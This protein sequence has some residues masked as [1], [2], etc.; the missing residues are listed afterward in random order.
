MKKR[1]LA[2]GL[3]GVMTLSLFGCASS[4]TT[5][6]T[7]TAATEASAE[8]EKL[9]TSGH[10]AMIVGLPLYLGEDLGIY[11]DYGLDVERTHYISGPPQLEALPSGA[12][13]I[14]W[15]G[16]AAANTAVLQH[17]AKIIGVAGTD[18]SHK[19]FVREDSPIYASGAGHVDG[20]P[21]LYGTA[22]DWR[23]A[24]ILCEKG[25]IHYMNLVLALGLLGVSEDEV[26]I[27]HMDVTSALQAFKAGEG[28]VFV[29]YGT[30]TLEAE[31]L[32]YK[33]VETMDGIDS[34]TPAV[35]ICTQ[36]ILD[37]RP[38]VVI[39]YLKGSMDAMLY[40]Q[41]E[42]HLAEN[43]EA[44][45]I[46]MTEESGVEFTDE[47]VDSSWAMYA[48]PDLETAEE[49]CEIDA[50]GVSGFQHLYASPSALPGALWLPLK[51]WPPTKALVT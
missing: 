16:M 28:D 26:E 1:L 43:K 13:E 35:L 21:E 5:E 2:L 46:F 31:S 8:M 51:C 10:V 42:S 3:A 50:D 38:E 40:I 49:L 48:W 25:T 45:K 37:E 41:D 39:D 23:G 32:G 24:T 36:E 12:W 20:Y 33:V 18:I 17:D 34:A 47:E 19:I 14:G 15:I 11:E 7:T 29:S 6:A 44:Y 4:T 30:P 22:D 27:V 9:L